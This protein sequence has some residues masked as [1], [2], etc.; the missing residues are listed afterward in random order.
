M[1]RDRERLVE[2]LSS[3]YPEDADKFRDLPLPYLRDLYPEYTMGPNGPKVVQMLD[4]CV[5][6]L[7]SADYAGRESVM[8]FFEN[9]SKDAI[10]NTLANNVDY[11]LEGLYN[12]ALKFYR[13]E[14]WAAAHVAIKDKLTQV[15]LFE[16]SLP[17]NV[18][19]FV[20]SHLTILCEAIVM[21][22]FVDDKRVE[23][24]YPNEEWRWFTREAYETRVRYWRQ[25]GNTP[26]LLKL[27]ETE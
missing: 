26:Y 25:I 15:K 21:E 20:A 6:L 14:A 9:I 24:M 23:K 22:D 8:A 2:W 27:G 18:L 17:S 3:A 13:E 16:S 5:A 7:N 19:D 1:F 12:I 10:L 4:H 11:N